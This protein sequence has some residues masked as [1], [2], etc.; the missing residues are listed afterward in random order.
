MSGSSDRIL[1]LLQQ[2]SALKELDDQYRAGPKSDVATGDS[3]Q[4]RKRRQ[5]IGKEMKELASGA[6]KRVRNRR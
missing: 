5:Q 6:R 2:I 1:E 3:R 4:R